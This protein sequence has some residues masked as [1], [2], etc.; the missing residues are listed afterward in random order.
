VNYERSG[1]AGFAA[2]WLPTGDNVSG[3]RTTL[4]L[5]Q[6]NLRNGYGNFRGV[7][8]DHENQIALGDRVQLRYGAEYIL[9]GLDHRAASLRPSGELAL[10]LAPAWRA[11]FSL[12][13]RPWRGPESSPTA[14]Q[15]ALETLDAFPVVM[16]RDG[17]TVL[18]GG[19][20]AEVALEHLGPSTR[21][22]AAVFH[23]A[24]PHV[25][26]FG[27]GQAPGAEFFQDSFSDS[28]AYDGGQMNAWGA[29]FVFKQKYGEN[30]ES[31]LVYTLAG[32]L[33]PDELAASGELRNTLASTQRFS[34]G[35]RVA[36]RVPRLG[37]QVAASYKWINGP[38][39]SRQDAFGELA[40]QLDPH[41]NLTI[42]QPLPSS[43]FPGRIEA[44]ADFR[45]LLAQGYVPVSTRD[46]TII[47]M[48]AFRAFRGG[49]S[50][51]F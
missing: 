18:E 33:A 23:D 42:R 36:T 50:F 2:T 44:L 28:F 16:F 3:P 30:V 19:Q 39:A 9:I 47:L 41:L 43:F 11:S 5:R 38:I 31:T 15:S 35:A 4:V 27:R 20:H 37:T 29:R 12:S 13:A 45:N 51:Q 8:L 34:L 10:L 1:G 32:A 40:Y 26:V 7:R 25:A 22:I 24:S 49:F 14:L 48:P 46:G 6:S 17:R 21:I